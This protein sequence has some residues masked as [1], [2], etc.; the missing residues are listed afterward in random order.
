MHEMF[1]DKCDIFYATSDIAFATV[2]KGI[3]SY[4]YKIY[5]KRNVAI[6]LAVC[7]NQQANQFHTAMN[8]D[9]FL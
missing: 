4:D 1:I 3:L 7:G 5:S 8:Y 2:T 6:A 9:R